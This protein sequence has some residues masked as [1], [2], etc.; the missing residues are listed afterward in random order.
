VND[1][2]SN[3][4]GDGQTGILSESDLAFFFNI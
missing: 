2:R 1:R 4:N 3:A